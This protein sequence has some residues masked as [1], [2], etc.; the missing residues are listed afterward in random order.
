M[1][2]AEETTI[3][4]ANKAHENYEK[5]VQARANIEG[6]FIVLG[7]LLQENQ[8]DALYKFLGYD[9]FNEYL[10]T[11]ELGFKRSTAYKLI[12]LINL[13]V[14]KLKVPANRLIG[15]GSTKL[16]AIS[17]VVENDVE[18]WL[19]KAEHLSKSSLDEEIDG[20]EPGEIKPSPPPVSSSPSDCVNGCQGD[21]D[22]HHFPVGRVS[23]CDEKGDWTIPLCRGCHTEYHREPKDWMWTYKKNWMRYL[24]NRVE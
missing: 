4:S 14:D 11:P 16:D 20:R 23:S 17:R 2:S 3:V 10:G 5:T 6:N 7:I 24:V 13:Y 21:V 9:T 18:G 8:R 22:R 19:S 12:A 1:T 15:V